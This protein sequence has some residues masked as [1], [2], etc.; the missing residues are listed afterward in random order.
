VD[1]YLLE[2]LDGAVGSWLAGL[3]TNERASSLVR[4]VRPLLSVDVLLR[5]FAMSG[6]PRKAQRQRS[7]GRNNWEKGYVSAMGVMGDRW[8]AVTN[9]N[10]W[11]V[12][13]RI[14][15]AMFAGASG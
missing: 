9:L 15:G 5:R 2:G 13:L 11:R 10:F 12:L 8:A 1:G 3:L 6:R 4:P 7:G 14:N